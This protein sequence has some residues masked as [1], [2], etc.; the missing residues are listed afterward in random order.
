MIGP[1]DPLAANKLMRYVP[2]WQC[3]NP[4]GVFDRYLFL[5]VHNASPLRKNHSISAT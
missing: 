1:Y 2:Y 5:Y 3:P 4:K